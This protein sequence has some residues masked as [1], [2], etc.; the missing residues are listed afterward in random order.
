MDDS[1]SMTEIWS[2]PWHALQRSLAWE[3]PQQLPSKPAPSAFA[4]DDAS[5]VSSW[6]ARALGG[7]AAH[8]HYSR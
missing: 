6:L 3:V 8:A 4:M 5:A 1:T 2:R 7:T